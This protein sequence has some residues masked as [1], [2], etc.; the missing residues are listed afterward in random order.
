MMLQVS[1]ELLS[2]GEWEQCTWEF[3]K[4]FLFNFHVIHL[5]LWTSKL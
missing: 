5:L 1:Q 4:D 3:Y 2:G